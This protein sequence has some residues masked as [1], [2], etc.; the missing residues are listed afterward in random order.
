MNRSRWPLGFLVL[1]LAVSCSSV[2][3]PFSRAP[4]VDARFLDYG[5]PPADYQSAVRTSIEGQVTP[6]DVLKTVDT[7]E[8]K[9]GSYL[10]PALNADNPSQP[11]EYF[12]WKVET[13][14][15]VASPSGSVSINR[16]VFF[17]NNNELIAVE[18]MGS[19][20]IR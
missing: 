16:R 10:P 9:K 19:S 6:P 20:A 8:P 1:L 5:P 4:R 2:S 3:N 7:S 15:Q 13:K 12:G 17:F 14:Y 11:V 18:K